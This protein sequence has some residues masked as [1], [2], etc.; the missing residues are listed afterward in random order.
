MI[1]AVL[2]AIVLFD[3]PP[4]ALWDFPFTGPGVVVTVPLDKAE[5]VCRALGV[6]T[7]PG[8]V[9]Y[10]CSTWRQGGCLIVLPKVDASIS[11]ADHDMVQRVENAN[12]NGWPKWGRE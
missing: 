11:Q 6:T 12:C 9:V 3:Y 2:L 8:H 7:K 10:G 5:Q 4:P 1:A